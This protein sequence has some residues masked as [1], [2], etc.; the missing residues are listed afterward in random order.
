MENEPR[1]VALMALRALYPDLSWS[2]LND[3]GL[4]FGFNPGDLGSLR[5]TERETST[6]GDR[7]LEEIRDRLRRATHI[8]YDDVHG[9]EMMT[10]GRD[11]PER[12]K[13]EYPEAWRESSKNPKNGRSP[14]WVS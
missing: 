12:L 9:H 11:L 14:R 5:D 2:E 13:E 6:K 4:H 7:K 3:L 10:E 1:A 8:D